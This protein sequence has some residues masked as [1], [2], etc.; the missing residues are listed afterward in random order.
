MA[1]VDSLNS[2]RDGNK[3]MT[4]LIVDDEPAITETLEAKFR[5]EGYTTFTADSAEDGMRLFKKVKPDLVILDIMLPNRSGHDFCRAIR[6]ENQT[7]IIFV[8]A[9]ASEDD[10][11]A[12]LELG[13]DDYVTKPYNM[14]ELSARVKAILRRAQGEPM[15]EVI[16]RGNVKIDPRTHEA[17]LDGKPMSLS[18]KEF[19]LLLFMA[20]N[21]GQVFTREALLDRVWG[22]DAYVTSR[23]VDVHIRWLRTRIEVDANIPERIVTV[24]GIGYKFVG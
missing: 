23:T 20:K 17:F 11:I 22:K 16:E 14:A 13:A 24:R 6:R 12:G 5:K 9:K 19:A 3:T 1:L 21:S 7:P 4:L 15:N 18:P 8:S 2:G 10:R